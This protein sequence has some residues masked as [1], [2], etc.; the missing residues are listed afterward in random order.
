MSPF[1]IGVGVGVTVAPVVVILEL[2][3]EDLRV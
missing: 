2:K 1:W 3:H